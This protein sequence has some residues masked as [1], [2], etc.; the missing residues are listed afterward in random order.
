MQLQPLDTTA[1]QCKQKKIDKEERTQ[2]QGHA[3]SACKKH[4]ILSRE[5]GC[6]KIQ[7]ST[8]AAVEQP[9]MKNAKAT[10]MAHSAV[11]S[12]LRG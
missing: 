11:R 2:R 9:V 5:G 1:E 10:A 12:A 7:F 6:S 4:E 8:G 3:V